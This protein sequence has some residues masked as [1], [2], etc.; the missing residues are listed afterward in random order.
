[1]EMNEKYWIYS[2]EIDLSQWTT[3]EIV[4][5]EIK[6]KVGLA[7]LIPKSHKVYH[8]WELSKDHPEFNQRCKEFMKK[9]KEEG[10]PLL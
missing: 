7:K 2:G 1:M 5:L 3:D 4:Q 10:L 6:E 8:L 9:L